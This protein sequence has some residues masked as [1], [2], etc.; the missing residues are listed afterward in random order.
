MRRLTLNWFGL[1][2]RKQAFR[3]LC[4]TAWLLSVT[5]PAGAADRAEPVQL[6]YAAAHCEPQASFIARVQR[7]TTRFQLVGDG[8][9]R[10][11]DVRV[12]RQAA[13]LNGEL[14]VRAGSASPELRRVSDTTCDGVMDALALMMALA[15]DPMATDAPKD[16]RAPSEPAA[17]P[18]PAAV[19]GSPSPANTRLARPDTGFAQAFG[20]QA[21]AH[22]QLAPTWLLGVRGF[23]ELAGRR[24]G[25]FSPELRL[26]G[27]YGR[28]FVAHSERGDAT[29]RLLE[30]V[31]ASCPL[32]SPPGWWRVGGC[33]QAEGGQL[34]ASGSNAPGARSKGRAWL[35]VGPALELD[36]RLERLLSL[37]VG[38]ALAF[39]LVRDRFGFGEEPIH[40]VP[41]VVP[42]VFLGLRAGAA[43]SAE[44]P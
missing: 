6:G 34:L 1:S 41:V 8:A 32:R 44:A 2:K 11:F 26:G 22:T 14:E 12:E 40:E 30:L 42:V 29:F 33:V 27:G 10:R 25:A 9:A 28:S 19:A 39:P 15:L 38:G 23:V 3:E 24:R 37:V 18:L 16:D 43:T 13:W 17:P 7:R 4:L 31:V 5:R 21:T 35:A 36:L 20:A